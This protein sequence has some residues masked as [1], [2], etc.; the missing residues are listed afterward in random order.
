[1]FSTA[2]LLECGGIGT[3]GPCRIQG[4]REAW[5]ALDIQRL[6]GQGGD[7]GEVQAPV[8]TVGEA[9]GMEQGVLDGEAHVRIG[10]LCFYG[11]VFELH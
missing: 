1:M 11:P 10:E 7:L 9:H 6:K 4:E 5:V 2:D 3:T 8:I